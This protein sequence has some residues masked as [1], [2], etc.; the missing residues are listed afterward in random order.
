[1]GD[2][3]RVYT[4][5]ELKGLSTEKVAELKKALEEQVKASPE[6]QAIIARHK[7]LNKSLKEKLKKTYDKLKSGG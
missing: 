4:P 2:V 5:D 7:E 6:V 1:M 3:S